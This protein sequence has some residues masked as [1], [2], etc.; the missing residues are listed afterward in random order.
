MTVIEA[1]NNFGDTR[2]GAS[3][4]PLA[5]AVIAVLAIVTVLLW[6]NMTARIKRLP[7]EFPA[8][9]AEHGHR[10]A[11]AGATTAESVATAKPGATDDGPVKSADDA[12]QND[13]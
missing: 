4:G 7:A 1:V 6:R 8:Q 12:G 2:E 13:R 10:S 9:P 3:A 5:L 11:E